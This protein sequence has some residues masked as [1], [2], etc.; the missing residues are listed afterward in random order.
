MGVYH[1]VPRSQA[2]VSHNNVIQTRW[3][4]V[5]KG[6]NHQ[7]DYRSIL[8][9]KEYRDKHVGETAAMFA[10]TPPTEILKVLISRGVTTDQGGVDRRKNRCI[11]SNDVKRAYFY[12]EVR[13]DIYIEI[14]PEDLTEEDENKY[15]VAKLRLSMYGTRE[16]AAAWQANIREVVTKLGF[17]TSLTNPCIYKHHARYIETMVHGDDFVSVADEDNLNWFKHKLAQEFDI[18]ISMIGWGGQT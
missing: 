8:V 9:A 17:E 14:P 16:A 4:N 1:K 11:M 7:P 15:V 5:N 2:A 3:I 10:A 6:D 18:K 13:S 12:A